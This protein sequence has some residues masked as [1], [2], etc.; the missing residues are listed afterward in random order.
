MKKFKK[1]NL[2]LKNPKNPQFFFTEKQQNLSQKNHWWVGVNGDKWKMS[3]RVWWQGISSSWLTGRTWSGHQTGIK[4]DTLE[5]AG[6][7]SGDSE[8]RSEGGSVQ[9]WRPQRW[10]SRKRCCCICN[11]MPPSSILE[12]GQLALASTMVLW[13]TWS[14]VCRVLALWKLRYAYVLE[15]FVGV[16]FFSPSFY[17]RCNKREEEDMRVDEMNYF[18]QFWFVRVLVSLP[19]FLP[20]LL[21]PSL[22]GLLNVLFLLMSH[23][24]PSSETRGF[25][26]LKGSRMLCEALR[27]FRCFKQCLQ[28]AYHE[29]NWRCSLFALLVCLTGWLKEEE[30]CN[31]FLPPFFWRVFFF[32]CTIFRMSRVQI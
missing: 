22:S 6:V 7:S 8:T 26:L 17:W 1:L 4:K 12:T 19:S 32:V 15:G 9:R 20:F 10:G 18:F 16:V 25:S 5:S 29:L 31:S 3:I 13:W 2:S 24:S 14:K 11:H 21:P 28:R 23:R 27:S 30:S